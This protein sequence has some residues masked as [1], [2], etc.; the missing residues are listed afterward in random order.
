MKKG[1]GYKEFF[2]RHISIIK[3][4]GLTCK[5]CGCKLKGSVREIAHI[6]PKSYFKSISKNDKNIIYLCEEHHTEFDNRSNDFVKSMKIFPEVTERFKQ[7]EQIIEEEINY[8]IYDR[9]EI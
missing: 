9:W 2:E 8:K 1:K 4:E 3:K 6:L 5:E 7:L